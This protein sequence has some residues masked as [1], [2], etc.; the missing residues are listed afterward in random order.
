MAR[1]QRISD[2][3]YPPKKKD[4]KTGHIT[5]STYSEKTQSSTKSIKKPR[6]RRT[7]TFSRVLCKQESSKAKHSNAKS[8]RRHQWR[9]C[10]RNSI[11]FLTRRLARRSWWQKLRKVSTWWACSL[12]R[13]LKYPRRA[14]RRTHSFNSWERSRKWECRIKTRSSIWI[15]RIKTKCWRYRSRNSLWDP[16]KAV[17]TAMAR[18]STLESQVW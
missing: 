6:K 11:K 17:L 4:A 7:S 13:G 5:L 15:L 8:G 18:P 3:L 14:E 16:L 12:P 10:P 1:A 9:G 2:L